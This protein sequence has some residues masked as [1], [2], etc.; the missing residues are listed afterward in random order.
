MALRVSEVVREHGFKVL[1]TG[2]G[3]DELFG[4]YPWQARLA[5]MWRLRSWHARLLPNLGPL[6]TLGRWLERLSPLD[7]AQL[8]TEPFDRRGAWRQVAPGLELAI[9]GGMRRHRARTLWARL[10]GISR[11]DQRAFLTR[12]FW[13]YYHYLPTLLDANDRMAMAASIEARVPFLENGMIDLGLHLPP[14]SKYVRGRSKRVVKAAAEGILPDTI[15]RAPKVG[16]A[17]PDTMMKGWEVLLKGGLVPE[18]FKWGA[19]EARRPLRPGA[20]A[21][22]SHGAPAGDHGTVGPASSQQEDPGRDGRTDPGPHRMSCT[23]IARSPAAVPEVIR[24]AK[25]Y[26]RMTRLLGPPQFRKLV[27]SDRDGRRVNEQDRHRSG[28]VG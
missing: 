8:A 9:D 12:Q 21:L 20:A 5:R 13:D 6:R 22:G 23:T 28:H 3:S 18:L 14:A 26:R 16:F 19:T 15:V 11:L 24:Q 25:P 2:E 1:I 17:V 27:Q 4:G 7:L 10:E